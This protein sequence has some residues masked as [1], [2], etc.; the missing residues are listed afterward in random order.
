MAHGDHEVRMGNNSDLRDNFVGQGS[1]SGDSFGSAHGVFYNLEES[2][3][4]E[5]PV[6]YCGNHGGG[7]GIKIRTRQPQRQP[8]LD[9][10]ESQGTAPR[11]IRLLMNSSPGSILN[12]NVRDSTQREEEE[13]RSTDTEV[14][15]I[16]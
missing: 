16:R 10:C 4:R 2:T 14:R 11:R 13:V 12:D 9:N 6:D 7:T 1:F 15:V 8:V 3:S 5:Y